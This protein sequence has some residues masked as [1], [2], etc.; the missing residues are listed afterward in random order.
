MAELNKNYNKILSELE[1]KI[2]NPQEL[3]FVKSKFSEMTVMFMDTIEKLVEY[4]EK[5]IKLE[6]KVKHIQK[7]L[8]RIEEDLYIDSDDEDDD[9]GCEDCNCDDCDEEY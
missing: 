2:K 7:S 1:E 9:C 5:Q 4:S 3:E 6:K 8:K